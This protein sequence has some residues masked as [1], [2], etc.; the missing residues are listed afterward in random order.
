M[1]DQGYHDL[2]IN[3]LIMGLHKLQTLATSE[4]YFIPEMVWDTYVHLGAHTLTYEAS[5]REIL[6]QKHVISLAH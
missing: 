3:H 1:D 2:V 4:F 6:L 5:G